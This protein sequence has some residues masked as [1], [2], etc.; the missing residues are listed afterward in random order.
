MSADLHNAAAVTP[1]VSGTD[2]L[3]VLASSATAAVFQIPQDWLRSWITVEG[4][5]CD[6]YHAFTKDSSLTLDDTATTTLVSNA[7]SSHGTGEAAKAKEDVP[8]H[9]DLSKLPRLNGGEEWYLAHKESAGSAYV[10]IT[11]SSGP[12]VDV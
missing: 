5:G 12:A 8:K 10:R 7:I 11:K 6:V 1:P 3:V 4:D 2:H 9:Y